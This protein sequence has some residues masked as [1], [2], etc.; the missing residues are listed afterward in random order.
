MLLMGILTPTP[1]HTDFRHALPL[2]VVGVILVGNV[3]DWFRREKLLIYPVA[4]GNVAAFLLGSLAMLS[5][6]HERIAAAMEHT[7]ELPLSLFAFLLDEGTAVDCERAFCFGGTQ[8]LR[9]RA[10]PGTRA[11]HLDIS[12]DRTDS[13]RIAIVGTHDQ[14]VV[15]FSPSD[16]RAGLARHTWE[17]VPPVEDVEYVTVQAVAGDGAYALGHL[18]LGNAP[19][20]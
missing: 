10:L 18:T 3:M 16:G 12:L 8:A 5:P 13:Y 17:V 7:T 14:R 6:W 1:H 11:T 9:L 2:L 4:L 19:L 15:T 20:R